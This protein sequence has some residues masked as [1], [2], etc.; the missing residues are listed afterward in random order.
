MIKRHHP[1]MNQT[2]R[3]NRQLCSLRLDEAGKPEV[4]YS[5][6]IDFAT[7]PGLYG[8][9]GSRTSALQGLRDLADEHH[10]CY[11]ALGLEKLSEGRG[12][13]ARQHCWG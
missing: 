9:Y 11:G 10:L 2:L 8:L 4:V 13:F 12:C 5:R 1:L 6:D 7:E 3:R